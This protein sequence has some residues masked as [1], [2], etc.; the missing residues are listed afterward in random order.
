MFKE[1]Q[2]NYDYVVV[3]IG[4]QIE[5]TFGFET[6]NGVV[7]GLTLL[8]DLNINHKQEDFKKYKKAIVWG[9]GN[10]AMDCARSLV[11]IID[12]V[13]IVYRYLYRKCL[14]VLQKSKPVKKKV[15]RYRLLKQH[16]RHFKG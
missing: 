2:T 14:Q 1:L 6:G 13:T 12:D 15:L 10:V 9:G 5:N 4:A 11:R 16:Q 7:A 3:A 8:Y